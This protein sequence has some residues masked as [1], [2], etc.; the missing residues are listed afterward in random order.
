MADLSSSGCLLNYVCD[1][2][3]GVKKPESGHVLSPWVRAIFRNGSAGEITVGNQSS[4]SL[5]N[6]ATIKSFDFGFSTGGECKI[7]IHDTQGS[8]LHNFLQNIM[9]ELTVAEQKS[10][11]MF[12]IE[13]GWTKSGCPSP[14]PSNKSDR[15]Y[16][17]MQSIETNF[18]QGK[19][20]HEITGTDTMSIATQG[21]V[22]KIIGGDVPRSAIPLKEALMKLLKEDPAPTVK[23][24]Q[25]LRINPTTGK[26]EE[27]D[28]EDSAKGPK[29][30]WKGQSAN[31]L[32][33]A[34]NWARGH[35]TNKKK[36]FVMRYNTTVDGGEVIFWESPT[37]GCNEIATASLCVGTY[38]VNGGKVSPVIE[39]NPK[40]K[41][42]FP[43]VPTMG[44]NIPEHAVATAASPQN[45]AMGVIECPQLSRPQ[46]KGA[47]QTLSTPTTQAH[48]DIYGPLSTPVAQRAQAQ[49][50]VQDGIWM[51]DN[52]IEADMVIVGDPKL[53]TQK[54]GVIGGLFVAIAYVNPFHLMSQQSQ[55][56]G[57]W[58]SKPPCNATLSNKNWQIKRLNHRIADGTYTTTFSL[59][60]PVPGYDLNL[61]EPLGG[62]PTGDSV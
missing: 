34:R 18:V 33:V 23:S 15:H 12:Y 22:E 30:S 48:I 57:D 51:M 16:L 31:K 41:W 55:N 28:F 7:V 38:V 9:K 3:Q 60:L 21:G 52:G 53:P 43:T 62:S 2:N 42:L 25:F 6:S 36:I 44:G 56:C 19:F 17:L 5:D 26:P 4:P 13:W 61:R 59:H 35:R 37:V 10:T 14:D 49:S 20:I 50:L 46:V 58:L 54:D 32:E 39:F 1:P 11:L 29:H 27:A 40:I 45:K 8:S 24:V 47:G